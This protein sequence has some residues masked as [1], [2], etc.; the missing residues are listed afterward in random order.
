[1]WTI[2]SIIAIVSLIAFSTRGPNA[3]WGGATAGL[4]IG[5]IVALVRDGFEWSTIWKGIVIGIILGLI[6]GIPPLIAE[7]LRKLTKR[8]E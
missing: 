3:I 5:A 1:M 7:I 2:L 6:T 8:M 4:I